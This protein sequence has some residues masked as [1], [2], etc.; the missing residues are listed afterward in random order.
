MIAPR[1]AGVVCVFAK[2]P[3]LGRVKTRL[4]SSVGATRACSLAEAFVAD[5]IDARASAGLPF[6]LAVDE[7][8]PIFSGSPRIMLQGPGDLGARMSHVLAHLLAEHAFVIALGTDSPGL[9][10]SFVARAYAWL[11]A[12][13]GPDAVLGPS[14]DGGFYL[15][16]VRRLDT[17]WLGG[18]RWST[19]H[20]R[21]DVERQIART[22]ARIAHLPEWFDV[23]LESDL[24][25]L[26]VT[27]DRDGSLRAP[28]TRRA[29]GLTIDRR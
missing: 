22:G 10:E 28:A 29:L 11:A 9:P 5:A 20:A 8:D 1:S 15:L 17:A 23:D 4:A 19:E 18:V 14:S 3:A 12:D 26:A 16:G 25:R 13:D 24:D 27:L 2:R 6:V 7:P 21:H